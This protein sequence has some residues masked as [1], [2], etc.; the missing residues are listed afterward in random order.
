MGTIEVI[1]KFIESNWIIERA[2]REVL[3]RL[4]LRL[5]YGISYGPAFRYWLGFLKESEKWNRDRL[6]AYQIEQ[7]RNLLIHAGKNVPYYKRVFK[8]YGFNPNR[9]QSLDDTKSLPYIDKKTLRTRSHDLLDEN[10]PKNRLIGIKTGGSTGIPV[11]V[12]SSKDTEEKHWATI[13]DLWSRVGYHPKAKIV[14][15]YHNITHG[16][17]SLMPF[18]KYANHL[19]IS[20][21]YSD[22]EWLNRYVEMVKAFGPE[23]IICGFPTYLVFFCAFMEEMNIPP[24]EGVKA[25]L[26]YC[27]GLMEWQRN[28]IERT[29]GARLFSSYGMTEKV[30]FGGACEHN[31]LIHLYPQYGV[32][33]ILNDNSNGNS[34]LVGTG[35]INYAMPLIKYR[36]ADVGQIYD[37]C[38]E[39]GRPHPLIKQLS[40]RV[41]DFLVDR[42]GKIISIIGV[43]TRSNC[44]D[45]VQAYQF[46]Q[47][48]KGKAILKI[49]KKHTYSDSD[50]VKIRD[51]LNK[52]L[53]IINNIDIKLFFVNDVERT[54]AGKMRVIVQKLNLKE[55][56]AEKGIGCF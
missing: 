46:Y 11:N 32:A 4:P 19:I 55:S 30:I 42:Y 1:K 16:K 29:L 14:S 28:I 7:L 3:E 6:E 27:E 34:E 51:E 9:V 41:G 52:K 17:K 35:F 40:G 25:V 49:V 36:T 31:D 50:S 39:C 37:F 24:F 26:I 18:K 13:V 21:N 48:E 53:G 44:F 38:K 54:S 12:Y 20:M 47:E 15:F 23:F 45:N 22:R 5:R 10:I 43:G 2:A 56:L 33:E 8:E